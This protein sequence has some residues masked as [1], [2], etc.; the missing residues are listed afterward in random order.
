MQETLMRR[1]NALQAASVSVLWIILQYAYLE[2]ARE[3]LICH[4][5]HMYTSARTCA[6]KSPEQA[7]KHAPNGKNQALRLYSDRD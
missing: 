1:K 6:I 3:H 7:L 4:T 2:D 5:S